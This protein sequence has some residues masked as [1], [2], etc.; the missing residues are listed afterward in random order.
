MKHDA[1]EPPIRKK[2]DITFTGK[3]PFV[4]DSGKVKTLNFICLLRHSSSTIY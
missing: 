4:A 2:T 3:A 1:L